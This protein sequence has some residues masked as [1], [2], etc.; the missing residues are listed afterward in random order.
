M[1]IRPDKRKAR[2]RDNVVAQ[3][4]SPE[5]R[6]AAQTADIVTRHART[7]PVSNSTRRHVVKCDRADKPVFD[8]RARAQKAADLLGL[9]AGMNRQYVYQCPYTDDGHWHLT[10]RPQ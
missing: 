5:R 1:G 7:A 2:D 8:D 9:L 4:R 10:S 6:F 3:E